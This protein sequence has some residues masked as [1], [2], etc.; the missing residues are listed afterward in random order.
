MV[1]IVAFVTYDPLGEMFHKWYFYK[2]ASGDWRCP[3]SCRLV[4]I[5]I[6]IKREDNPVGLAV[7]KARC[8]T[9]C[10]LV[11][12]PISIKREDNP[13]GLAVMK[14]RCPRSCRLVVIPIS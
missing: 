8:P 10:Q 3:T 9:S 14:A 6:S 5:P 7:M 2:V 13:V 4:V 12:I 11:V 1:P